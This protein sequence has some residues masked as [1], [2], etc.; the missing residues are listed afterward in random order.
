ML[1]W[2]MPWY[3]EQQE[4]TVGRK[5]DLIILKLAAAKQG[6]QIPV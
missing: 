2:V 5:P 4:E 1:M 6:F 3:V